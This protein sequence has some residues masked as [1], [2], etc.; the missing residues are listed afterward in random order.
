MNILVLTIK[1]KHFRAEKI[2][3]LV[4]HHDTKCSYIPLAAPTIVSLNFFN[5]LSL[6]RFY[7]FHFQAQDESTQEFSI[8]QNTTAVAFDRET[9]RDLYFPPVERQHFLRQEQTRHT[10]ATDQTNK[11]RSKTQLLRVE[12]VCKGVSKRCQIKR[13][14]AASNETQPHGSTGR[15]SLRRTR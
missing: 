6:N 14:R 1:V 10:A 11:A 7:R 9:R 4:S 15:R 3:Q 8:E 5:L 13:K 2:Y 12:N